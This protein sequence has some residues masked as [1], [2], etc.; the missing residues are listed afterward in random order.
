[1]NPGILITCLFA[2]KGISYWLTWKDDV[3]DR[4]GKENGL[5]P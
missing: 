2:R 1:M 4:C 3:N 5:A